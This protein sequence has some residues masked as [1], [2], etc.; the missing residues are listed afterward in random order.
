VR[1]RPAVLRRI[2][3]RP[4][5]RAVDPVP[6]IRRPE[7]ALFIPPLP[8]QTGTVTPPPTDAAMPP[9]SAPS[10]APPVPAPTAAG[11]LA[12]STQASVGPE[13]GVT[14]AAVPTEPPPS[15]QVTGGA[16]ATGAP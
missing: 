11:T 5:V 6:E 10:G 3:N 16:P 4:Q 15:S 7:E 1:A 12:P 14:I 9:G 8:E 2:S 13:P